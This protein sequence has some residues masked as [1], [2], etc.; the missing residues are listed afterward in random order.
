MQKLRTK[1]IE[2]LIV[3]FSI[4]PC[5]GADVL[6]GKRILT[7]NSGEV[8][9]LGLAN[10]DKYLAAGS[11]QGDI[12]V[13]E[14]TNWNQLF[15]L[16]DARSRLSNQGQSEYGGIQGFATSS[17]ESILAVA[18]G[19]SL[20]SVDLDTGVRT[21]LGKT[22]AA[23]LAFTSNGIL[24]APTSKGRIEV[25][26]RRSRWEREVFDVAGGLSDPSGIS[27]SLNGQLAAIASR[28]KGLVL[29]DITS[30][31]LKSILSLAELEGDSARYGRQVAFSPDGEFVA[32][33]VS[34]LKKRFLAVWDV[35]SAAVVF[36]SKSARP[37]WGIAFSPDGGFLA[38]GDSEGNIT[39]WRLT[40]WNK[41]CDFKAQGSEEL[42]VQS[43]SEWV[44]SGGGLP[45]IEISSPRECSQSLPS[46]S[47]GASANRASSERFG[48][49]TRSLPVWLG[50][51]SRLRQ[52]P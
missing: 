21:R 12:F 36:S 19:G 32:A 22:D 3:S 17:T 51:R 16:R 44:A 34:K 15:H 41:L 39:L 29:F 49:Q 37:I 46:T 33:G 24:V 38:T 20:F 7:V 27:I 8:V 35:G 23:S 45:R 14:T 31:S 42:A 4:L 30:H 10:H 2:M 5:F 26:T 28:G 1:A 6:N 48:S 25:W 47:L 11:L 13:W 40:N 18:S 52:S 43:K 9:A 50:R